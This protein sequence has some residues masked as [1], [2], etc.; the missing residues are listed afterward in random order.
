M[1]GLTSSTQY[2]CNCK[3]QDIQSGPCNLRAVV[4]FYFPGQSDMEQSNPSYNGYAFDM[5]SPDREGQ[6]T[7]YTNSTMAGQ[8]AVANL[9]LLYPQT[10]KSCGQG[11]QL[12]EFFDGIKIQKLNN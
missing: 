7:A 1:L 6:V 10:A 11:M 12:Q 8:D 4:C 5:N 2:D 3:N 9:F